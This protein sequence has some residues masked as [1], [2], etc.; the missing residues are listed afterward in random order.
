M[1]I[2]YLG[3]RYTVRLVDV[4]MAISCNS[5]S[6]SANMLSKFRKIQNINYFRAILVEAILA[7]LL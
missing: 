1:D 5:L 7:Y 3:L 4:L 2:V 6:Q